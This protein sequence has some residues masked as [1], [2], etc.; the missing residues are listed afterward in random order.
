M[1][2]Y[3]MMTDQ[4]L[5]GYYMMGCNEAFDCWTFSEFFPQLP[6][7]NFFN[8]LSFIFNHLVQIT[9]RMHIYTTIRIVSLCPVILV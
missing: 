9:L 6:W 3:K 7:I 4:M 5:V 1:D 8:T 2:K